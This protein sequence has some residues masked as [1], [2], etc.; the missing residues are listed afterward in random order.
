[1]ERAAATPLSFGP[2][3]EGAP[4]VPMEQ[5]L[6]KRPRP[7]AEAEQVRA[8]RV[9]PHGPWPW[10]RHPQQPCWSPHGRQQAV[11]PIRPTPDET[12]Q[13][14]NRHALWQRPHSPWRRPRR[15]G[16]A[17]RDRVALMGT[18]LIQQQIRTTPEDWHTKAHHGE[19]PP[20]LH[21]GGN[22]GEGQHMPQ[23]VTGRT[24][25]PNPPTL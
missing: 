2:P 10:P 13:P 6:A 12:H 3:A 25:T 9:A 20:D 24:L 8:T 23:N 1:M 5:S 18:L 21:K 14:S 19:T 15:L 7:P 22:Q 4:P 16:G 11:D 17:A